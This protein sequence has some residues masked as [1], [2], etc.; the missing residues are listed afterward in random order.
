MSQCTPS[1]TIIKK[2]RKEKK[3]ALRR[4]LYPLKPI[5]GHREN[6]LFPISHQHR[7]SQCPACRQY[8]DQLQ[9][10]KE[11][12]AEGKYFLHKMKNEL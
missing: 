6:P 12:R 3:K 5:V 10:Q 9:T 1:T 4:P 11:H 7:T 2:K 8:K